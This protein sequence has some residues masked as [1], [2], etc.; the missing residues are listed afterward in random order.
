[1]IATRSGFRS[2]AQ[3][4]ACQAAPIPGDGTPKWKSER[5]TIRSPSSSGGSP[6]SATSSS[7]SRTQ[8]ASSRPQPRPAA[9]ERAERASDFQPLERRPRVDDVALELQ[10]RLLEPGRDADELREVEDRHA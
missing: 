2:R 1:M 4:A 5:C 8:P 3:T 6:G 7:R 10:L 9:R